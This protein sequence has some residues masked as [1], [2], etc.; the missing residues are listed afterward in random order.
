M[1]KRED[2]KKLELEI[3]FMGGQEFR[4]SGDYLLETGDSSRGYQGDFSGVLEQA[5]A[6]ARPSKFEL[7][8]IGN[9]WGEGQYTRGARPGKHPM[10]VV[11]EIADG[12][13][14]PDSV[15]PQAIRW[16]QGYYEAEKH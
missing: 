16:E 15:P 13:F 11:F 12:T 8:A 4:I 2:I 7:L 1:W 14:A 9:H 5:D 10:G 6:S 3:K